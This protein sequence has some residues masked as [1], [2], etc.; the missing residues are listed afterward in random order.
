MVM[1][2]LDECHDFVGSL[3]MVGFDICMKED[4]RSVKSHSKKPHCKADDD[5]A[6]DSSWRQLKQVAS[7]D[8]A[9]MQARIHQHDGDKDYWNNNRHSKESSRGRN[10]DQDRDQEMAATMPTPQ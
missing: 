6:S 3:E 8:D 9:Q 2:L 5:A 1:H 7:V 4:E 10:R